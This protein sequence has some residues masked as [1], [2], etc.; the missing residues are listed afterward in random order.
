MEVLRG[1]KVS[2]SWNVVFDE[3]SLDGHCNKQCHC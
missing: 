1:N 3:A 2:T